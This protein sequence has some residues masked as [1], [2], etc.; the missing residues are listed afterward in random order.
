MTIT[1]R[2]YTFFNGR[3]VGVDQFGNRYFTEKRLPKNRRQRRWVMYKGIAEPSKVPPE[4]HGWLHYTQEKPPTERK[5]KHYAW[6]KPHL[7]NLT[8]TPNA[9]LPPGDL[10]RGGKRAPTTADYQAWRP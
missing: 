7:P 5:I 8:G 4:W 10:K 6:E 2:L 1:T 3:F 9:Y